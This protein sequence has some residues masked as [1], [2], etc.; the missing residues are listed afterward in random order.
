MTA[1]SGG[2][3]PARARE[4]VPPPAVADEATVAPPAPDD[5]LRR[6]VALISRYAPRGHVHYGRGLNSYAKNLA[7]SL[8]RTGVDVTVFADRIDGEEERYTEDGVNV[9]RIWTVGR[10]DVAGLVAAV[11]ALRPSLVHLQY[12]LF[13]FGPSRCALAPPALLRRLQHRVKLVT[14]VHGVIPPRDFRA[15]ASSYARQV[16]PAATRRLYSRILR[17]VI[18]SSDLVVAH[19]WSLLTSICGY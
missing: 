16:P 5:G 18:R 15:L 19:N 11:D 8:V 6:T 3:A 1:P 9:R 10:P 17:R 7:T 14:T 2:A 4:R 12:E 13:M